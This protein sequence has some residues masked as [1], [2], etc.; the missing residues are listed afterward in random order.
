MNV[1][2]VHT[3]PSS[4]VKKVYGSYRLVT[5]FVELNKYIRPLPAKLSTTTYDIT[6]LGKWT[7]IIKTDLKSAYYQIKMA[8]WG[9]KW[10]GIISPYKGLFVYDKVSIGFRN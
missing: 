1:T 4:L 6:A 7:Y 8:P 2:V 10:L 9:R 5:N 3:S